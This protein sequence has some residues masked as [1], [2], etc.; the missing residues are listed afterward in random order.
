MGTP[1]SK[2]EL[3][4]HS[5]WFSTL[6]A[7]NMKTISELP[8]WFS[9]QKLSGKLIIGGVGLFFLVCLCG[10]L[11]ISFNRPRLSPAITLTYQGADSVVLITWTP[12]GSLT[13]TASATPTSTPVPTRTPLPTSL[14]TQSFETA[15]TVILPTSIRPALRGSFVAIVFVDKE[16]EYVDIQ[17]LSGAPV[18][19]SG[20]VLVSERG[21]QSCT[22]SG[23][24]QPNEVRRIWA[25][26]NDVG[27]SCG[28]LRTIWTDNELDPAV[29]YNPQGQE[30]SRYP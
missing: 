4:N 6:M 28:F 3:Y 18:Y 15:T 1:R 26:T 30:V 11:T 9:Q 10:V 7:G 8:G 24:L 19:L 25:G 16:L 17:N 22:L 21:D 14:P 27:Y 20:W 23:V 12:A 29:L 13:P 2:I 5:S